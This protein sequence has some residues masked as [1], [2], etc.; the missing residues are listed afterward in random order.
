M[1]DLT[2]A[3]S[4]EEMVQF[5]DNPRRPDRLEATEANQRNERDSSLM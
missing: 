3:A 1:E 4:I 2:A 5:R